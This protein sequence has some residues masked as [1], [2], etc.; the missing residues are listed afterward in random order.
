[1]K[2]ETKKT[3]ENILSYVLVF[4][5]LAVVPFLT[6]IIFKVKEEAMADREQLIYEL[7]EARTEA[8]TYEALSEVFAELYE[9][10][11]E[12]VVHTYIKIEDDGDF[13]LIYKNQLGWN[14]LQ[15]L[16]GIVVEERCFGN[17]R[18]EFILIFLGKRITEFEII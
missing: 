18:E 12:E 13:E 1:M 9:E 7:Y 5:F 8:E 6:G 3:I 15:T 16:G 2:K 11:K 14:Y 4:L 10:A 17:V